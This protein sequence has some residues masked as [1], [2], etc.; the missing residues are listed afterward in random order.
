LENLPFLPV[1]PGIRRTRLYKTHFTEMNSLPQQQKEAIPEYLALL[2]VE[3]KEL[4]LGF[5]NAKEEF[6]AKVVAFRLL[7]GFGETD[8]VY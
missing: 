6:K 3:T 5:E 7:G 2:E 1:K 4:A 8:V